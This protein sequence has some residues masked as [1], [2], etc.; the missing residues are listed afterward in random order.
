[1]IVTPDQLLPD[2]GGTYRHRTSGRLYV[3]RERYLG[4]C[5]LMTDRGVMKTIRESEFI[6]KLIHANSGQAG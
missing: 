1:M 3:L 2:V 5:F 6:D 4:H